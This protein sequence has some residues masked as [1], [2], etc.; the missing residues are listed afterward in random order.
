M[1][2]S[3]AVGDLGSREFDGTK[4]CKAYEG[5]G[6]EEDLR[7]FVFADCEKRG[8]KI[9]N[10]T[11]GRGDGEKLRCEVYVSSMRGIV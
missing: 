4:F 1:D 8:Y 2:F 3:G 5:I 10:M 9:L 6:S 11:V 7:R